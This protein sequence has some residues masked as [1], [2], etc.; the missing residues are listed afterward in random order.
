M[1]FPTYSY[2][3]RSFSY[4]SENALGSR[5]GEERMKY[6]SIDRFE[7]MLRNDQEY[8]FDVDEFDEIIEHYM[9]CSLWKKALKAVGMGMS[10]HP[11]ST[12][13]L[14]RKAQVLASMGKLNDALELLNYL[15]PFESS[16][17]ELYLSKASIYSQL[18][19]YDEAIKNYKLGIEISNEGVDD[20]YLDLAF[21]YENAENYEEAVNALKSALEINPEN[22]AALYELVY[23]FDHLK[24]DTECIT[25]LEEFLDDY[26]Y[27]F[28]GW[29]N[30]GNAFC[31][32]S[33]LEKAIDAY[34]YCIA[35]KETFSSAHFNK[36]NTLVQLERYEDAIEA[37]NE[38]LLYEEPDG[39]IYNYI[40]ECF[41]KMENYEKALEHYKLA[42]ELSPELSDA[43]LGIGIV[44]DVQGSLAESIKCIEKAI[45]LDSDNAEYWGFYGEALEKMSL[46]NEAET[47]FK[48]ALELDTSCREIWLSFS[49]FS[50]ETHGA[51]AAI[52]VITEGISY[53]PN[54][55]EF[56]YRL[57]AYL[58]QGRRT[59]EALSL[60]TATL[61]KDYAKHKLLLEYFPEAAK[62]KGVLDLIESYK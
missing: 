30:L 34:S 17:E 24:N 39:L 21:E 13:L 28:T 25:F 44:K 59:K 32:V 47:A 15:E 20:L 16:N 53:L 51:E 61:K 7:E 8:F 2:F 38:A 48:R 40:G 3:C 23:C 35:I 56:E 4:F 49:N 27:S 62:I 50:M 29:Y 1:F 31:K 37:Y 41:E 22:E 54:D 60:L 14:L 11:D 12:A 43:W 6:T 18:R 5:N 9:S 10:Q 52:D 45:S 58:L 42:I 33:E 26:P 19:N 57:I 36:A 55:I 46:K